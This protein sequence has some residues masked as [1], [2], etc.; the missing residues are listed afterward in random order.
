MFFRGLIGLWGMFQSGAAFEIDLWPEEGRPVFEAVA[1]RLVIR[2][3][4]LSSGRVVRT[5]DV[6][7]TD[8]L[9]FDSTRFRTVT[10]GAFVALQAADIGGRDLGDINALSRADYYSGKFASTRIRVQQGDSVSYLQYRAEGTC[11]VR[12]RGTVVDAAPCPTQQ[13]SAFRVSREPRTEWWIRVVVDAK[14]LGW[15]LV[16][17]TTARV[18]RRLG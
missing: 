14:P 4:P 8:L 1:S 5:L 17:D 12:M 13:P 15:L 18:V 10:P 3:E 6:H 11:F 7:P 16:T 9:A 2:A